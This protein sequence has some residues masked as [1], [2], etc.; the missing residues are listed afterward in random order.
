MSTKASTAALDR[1]GPGCS[2]PSVMFRATRLAARNCEK[3]RHTEL[4]M[5]N[6]GKRP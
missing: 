4:E 5:R 3:G 2:S 1:I 6:P